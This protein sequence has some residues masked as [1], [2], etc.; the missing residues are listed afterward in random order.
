VAFGMGID[1]ADVRWVFNESVSD[2]VDSLYQELGRAGRDGSPAEARLF[3]RPEDLGLRRYFAGGA[4][5]RDTMGRV[6]GLLAT[7]HRPVDPADI[8]QDVE[9]SRTKLST[10][11]H[12]LETAGAVE[13]QED[14]AVRA[15]VP[16]GPELQQAIDAAAEAEEHRLAFDRSRIEMMRGYAET[17]GCRRAFLLGYF[18]EAFEPPC[19]NC[20]NCDAGLVAQPHDGVVAEW[21]GGERVRHAEWG[22]G[23]VG[24]VEN[25]QITIVFDEIGY[26]TLAVAVVDERGLLERV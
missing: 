4:V 19:G 8:L 13:V 15:A 5:D 25:D 9:V 21:Q 3:Y 16:D 6:A 10:A 7:V 18:G 17:R 20:D 26:K 24:Q 11:L 22:E 14:G 2:S 23:T 12:R 1:K